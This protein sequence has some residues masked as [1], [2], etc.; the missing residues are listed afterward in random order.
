MRHWWAD[1]RLLASDVNTSILICVMPPNF[2]VR[3]HG[4]SASQLNRLASCEDLARIIGV[5]SALRD[6][7]RRTNECECFLALNQQWQRMCGRVIR[8]R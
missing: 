1:G 7:W 6:Q 5:D 4:W 8:S 3:W 2:E